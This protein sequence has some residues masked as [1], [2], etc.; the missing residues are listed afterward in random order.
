MQVALRE[1]SGFGAKAVASLPPADLFDH[2]GLDDLY[3][4]V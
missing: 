1:R 3:N 4:P 2:D